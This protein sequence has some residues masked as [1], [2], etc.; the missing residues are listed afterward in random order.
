MFIFFIIDQNTY[1]GTNKKF[2][3]NRKC[4]LYIHIHFKKLIIMVEEELK[5]V[6]L[7]EGNNNDLFINL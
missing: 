6:I 7:A 1:T 3:K 2:G 5:E 4:N